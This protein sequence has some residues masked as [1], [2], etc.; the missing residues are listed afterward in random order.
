MYC[1]HS[2]QKTM[3]LKVLLTVAGLYAPPCADGV[4]VRGVAI[5]SRTIAPGDLFVAVKGASCDGAM[6]I[7]DALARGAAAVV[8]EADLAGPDTPCHVKVE[9]SRKAAALLAK[10]FYLPD[11]DRLKTVVV[12]GTNGKT[13]FTYL[14]ESIFAA[15]G[16]KCGVIGT[17]NARLGQKTMSTSL[18]TPD[19]VSLYR[20]LA[21]MKQEGAETVVM[22]ASSHALD[23]DRLFG[24]PVE[25]AVFTNLGRDHLDYHATIEDYFA[26]KL[27]LFTDYQVRLAVVNGDD[28]Y[29]G[30]I[31]GITGQ[32]CVTFGLSSR[33][34]VH[35]VHIFATIFSTS[36]AFHSHAGR[37]DVTS[38]MIGTHNLMNIGAA[39]AASLGL[40]LE[41]EMISAGIAA[42]TSIPGRL[43][44]VEPPHGRPPYACL[45]DYA[46][47]PDAVETVLAELRPLTPGRII[48]VLG[49]GGDRDRGKRPLMG[50]A[51]ATGS[52][53]AI[54]TSDNPRS[55]APSEIIDDMTSG[56]DDA[57]HD[58]QV[59]PD[60]AAAIEMAIKTARPG[61]CV[62]IAG[63]GHED[64]QE[65]AGRRIHFSDREQAFKEVAG[66]RP[67]LP[68]E[69]GRSMPA[70]VTLERIAA[71]AGGELI[72]PSG[73]D[74]TVRIAGVTTDSRSVQEGQLFVALRGERFDGHDY[75]AAAVK[76]GAAAVMVEKGWL[77][78][79]G[80]GSLGIPLIAVHDTLTA[81]GDMASWYR[82]RLD[83]V[84]VA[85]TG[86]CGK[87][88][89]KEM[90]AAIIA[91]DVPVLKTFG[92]HNNLVGVPLTL[93]KLSPLEQVAVV[94][95]GTNRPGEIGRL[96]KMAAPD[97]A[98]ITN[99][100]PAHL[101]GLGG[102]DQ[103][104][105][106]KNAIW[107][108]L[109][110][111][112]TCVV[113][114]DDPLISAPWGAGKTV[115]FSVKRKDADVACM[116]F[117]PTPSGT[118]I[119]MLYKGERLQV[120]LSLVG[121]SSVQNALAA[122]AAALAVGSSGG[123]VA[124]G[125]AAAR[126][127]TGRL[128]PIPL[129]SFWLLD[130]SY[131]ANPASMREGLETLTAWGRHEKKVAVLGEMKELGGE[132][133]DLHADL[134]KSAASLLHLLIT[135]GQEAEAAAKAAIEAGMERHNVVHFSETHELLDWLSDP[136]NLSRLRDADV[137]IKGSRAVGLEAVRDLLV[138]QEGR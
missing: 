68:R 98:L 62:L 100:Q 3:N 57:G 12:T 14:M 18:T 4:E 13:S 136:E 125:L 80:S 46:H 120:C 124:D 114:L 106:E 1:N 8:T 73:G 56:L 59:E 101:E 90:A 22:E 110:S 60:R 91:Q 84:I 44:P 77:A 61:D 122:A 95:M 11:A 20:L 52:D 64:Y 113:N 34:D 7:A 96:S 43:E 117:K 45:I 135:V 25:C 16:I 67:T 35:P 126:P 103:V 130:D 2:A 24:L 97:V 40:G 138:N 88:T 48:T 29:G 132:S 118:E 115:T 17:I 32:K 119:E 49:C 63:K 76:T 51:A 19:P 42:L 86:S 15:A 108:G 50:K 9:E 78:Q 71:A 94:E 129:P 21:E 28:P 121:R 33:N 111:D 89:T 92:N 99:I 38:R 39:I 112:G 27:R 70:V 66:H 116:G 10:A 128:C 93:L 47:T 53:V 5:D 65:I 81:L 85:V 30:R 104:A 55:E 58:Y 31:A 75:V 107:Q 109:S 133:H 6:F 105:A 137:L 127:V 37:I 36:A 72:M 82:K 79:A 69:H 102:L 23:Q 41:P 54:F 131:N 134:G 74:G 26:S 87:T 83:P 123:A